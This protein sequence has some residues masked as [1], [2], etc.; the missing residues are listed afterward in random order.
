MLFSVPFPNVWV[1]MGSAGSQGRHY[2]HASINALIQSHLSSAGIPAQLEPLY[3]V[4]HTTTTTTVQL[5]YNA[6]IQYMRHCFREKTTTTTVITQQVTILCK[7]HAAASSKCTSWSRVA[8]HLPVYQFSYN[9]HCMQ[10]PSLQ[11]LVDLPFSCVGTTTAI[12]QCKL[13]SYIHNMH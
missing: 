4:A 11:S 1:L 13:Q 9:Q 3:H 7:P 12:T 2:Y 8:M 6:C 5:N 10:L